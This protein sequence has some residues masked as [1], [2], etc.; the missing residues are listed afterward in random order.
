MIEFK[1][2]IR[3]AENRMTQKDL[4]EATGIN[5]N[6]ISKYFN[7]TSEKITKEHL[8]ILCKYFNCKI[9]DIIEYIPDEEQNK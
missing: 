8:N 4:I 9:E 5:K 6:T 7:N 3:L 1:L 2:H